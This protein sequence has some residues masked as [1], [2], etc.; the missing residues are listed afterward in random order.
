M[1]IQFS[2]LSNTFLSLLFH[3]L[4]LLIH[5]LSLLFHFLSLLNRC[6]V[7]VRMLECLN[8]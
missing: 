1:A 2:L 6:F 7:L 5:F 8:L 3:F 4:S